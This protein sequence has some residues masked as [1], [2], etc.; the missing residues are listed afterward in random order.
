MS[1]ARTGQRLSSPFTEVREAA[2]DELL[3]T[4]AGVT[5]IVVVAAVIAVVVSVSGIL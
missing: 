5:G 3:M 4:I 1:I 2:R